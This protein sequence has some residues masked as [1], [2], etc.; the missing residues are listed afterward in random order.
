M[1]HITNNQY[2]RGVFLT[3]SKDNG[4]TFNQYGNTSWVSYAPELFYCDWEYF[5][6]ENPYT[7][8]PEVLQLSECGYPTMA[9]SIKNNTLIFTWLN[10]ILQFPVR[11]AT[12][13]PDPWVDSAMKVYSVRVK[14]NEIGYT[15]NNTKDVWK[16]WAINVEEQA[17]ENLKVYPNPATNNV[18]VNIG[19]DVPF[20]A[21]LTNMVGQTVQTVQGQKTANIDVSGYPSGIYILN[22]K[23]AKATTSQKL[24]VR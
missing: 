1:L 20:T 22:V 3:V 14:T 17:L 13:S 7:E 10:D 6:P 15:Y 8:I 2:I 11:P 16:N 18:Y 24:I 21:T 12:G 9:Q 5:N 19:V 4:E 23:T